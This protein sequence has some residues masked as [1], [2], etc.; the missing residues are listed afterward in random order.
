MCTDILDAV[1]LLQN[2]F[3]Q[4]THQ[5]ILKIVLPSMISV[6]QTPLPF[7]GNMYMHIMKKGIRNKTYD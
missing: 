5:N 2:I 4:T 6:W 1:E 7:M 3:Y